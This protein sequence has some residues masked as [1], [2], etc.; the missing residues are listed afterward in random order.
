VNDFGAR[1]FELLERFFSDFS[2][3]SD[4]SLDALVDLLCLREGASLPEEDR[5]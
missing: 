3:G 4:S 1:F 2:S 5:V